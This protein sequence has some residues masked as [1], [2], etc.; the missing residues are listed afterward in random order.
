MAET[1]TS[2]PVSVGW[3]LSV[4]PEL[5]ELEFPGPALLEEGDLD[6]NVWD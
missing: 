4:P 6:A 3:G 5:A 2:V 1:S